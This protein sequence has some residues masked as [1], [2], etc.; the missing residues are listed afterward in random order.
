MEVQIRRKVEKSH[1][2]TKVMNDSK[3][4]VAS[5][6]KDRK[7]LG[8][9]DEQIEKKLLKKYLRIDEDDKTYGDQRDNFWTEFRILVPMSGVVLNIAKDENGEYI[10]TEDA[11]RYF[12]AKGHPLV[13]DSRSEMINNPRKQF[14]I[15]DPQRE[16]QKE[17]V[18]VQ[19]K[20]NA[21]IEFANLSENEEKLA[22]VVRLLIGL[23]PEPMTKE[24]QENHLSNYIEKNPAKFVK[25]VTDEDLEIRAEI[26]RMV[27]KGILRKQGN[28]YL[29]MDT[30]IGDSIGESISF[31]KNKRNSEI[32]LDLRSKLKD[33]V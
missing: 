18:V 16:S 32:V 9:A 31:F 1:L 4:A 7:P 26:T 23:D 12:W 24:D 6:L 3:K 19:A 22:T 21:Y 25:T 17:N 10:N 15:Y 13:A 20:K 27:E 28:S 29:Y 33:L 14:Y 5:V 8:I 30:T 11:I 2:P